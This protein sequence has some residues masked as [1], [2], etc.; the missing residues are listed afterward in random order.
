MVLFDFWACFYPRKEASGGGKI[1]G[2]GEGMRGAAN[3][4]PP[5]RTKREHMGEGQHPPC[6]VCFSVRIIP[7]RLGYRWLTSEFSAWL[8][9]QLLSLFL[10]S[11]SPFL[12][13]LWVRKGNHSRSLPPVVFTGSPPCYQDLSEDTVSHTVHQNNCLVGVH[14]PLAAGLL[15]GVRWVLMVRT[16]ESLVWPWHPTAESGPQG[17]WGGCP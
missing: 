15:L 9:S 2:S 16:G 5:P 13:L 4:I 14:L 3:V 17:A 11:S 12:C 8:A 10:R 7:H 6:F 1:A